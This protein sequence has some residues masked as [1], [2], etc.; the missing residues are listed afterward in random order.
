MKA[1]VYLDVVEQVGNGKHVHR[2]ASFERSI[3]I[4][5]VPNDGHQIVL[6]DDQE[7]EHHLVVQ[8]STW[9]VTSGS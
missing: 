6:A 9:H 8:F 7:N 3:H 1:N 5:F 4:P 2:V